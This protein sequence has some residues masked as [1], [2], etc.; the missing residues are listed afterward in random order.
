MNPLILYT[1]LISFCAALLLHIFV[2]RARRPKNDILAL[3]VIFVMIPTVAAAVGFWARAG[4]GLEFWDFAAIL[5]LH[6]ALS[7]MYIQS[8]PPAQAVSPSLQILI[9]VGQ[10]AEGLTREEILSLFDDA[11]MVAIRF[12]DL[13]HTR[14]IEQ[15]GESY[16]LAPA[17]KRLIGF[18]VAY[19]KLLGLEFK[20][21]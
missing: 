17:G 12:Q 9:Y 10:S 8:Y 5:V 11:K 2:W 3:L 13:I 18:F 7:A 15:K 16:Q 19:R 14:L 6:L 21:G 1:A 20:G 4:L